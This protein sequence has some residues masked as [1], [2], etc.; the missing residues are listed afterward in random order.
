MGTVPP[1]PQKM[2]QLET[3]YQVLGLVREES[4]TAHAL[5][6][7]KRACLFRLHSD[8]RLIPDDDVTK[9]KRA[10]VELAHEI[11]SE[12]KPAYDTLLRTDYD[13]IKLNAKP[14]TSDNLRA[15]Q[16]RIVHYRPP[17]PPRPA[18]RGFSVTLP[19]QKNKPSHIPPEALAAMIYLYFMAGDY[20]FS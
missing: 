3:F 19:I 2:R 18:M 16:N 6:T 12:H 11:L 14:M 4:H 20:R 15:L 10:L 9:D 8:K 17:S 13:T 1:A 7:A 5:S